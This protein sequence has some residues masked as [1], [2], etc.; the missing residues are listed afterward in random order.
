MR[1][2]G[3]V[4]QPRPAA[5]APDPDVRGGPG[6]EAA[7]RRGGGGGPGLAEGSAGFGQGFAPIR[8][9]GEQDLHGLYVAF[10]FCLFGSDAIP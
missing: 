7:G 2:E 8:E 6:V 9:R 1:G 5:E 4:L 10:F 3:A